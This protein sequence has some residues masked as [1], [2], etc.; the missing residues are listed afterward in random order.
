MLLGS[1]L[2]G[3]ASLPEDQPVMEQLDS[4]T[5]L[6]VARLGKPVELYLE[7]F[8]QQP[9]G[10]FAFIGPFETNS[11][12]SRALFLWVALPLDS[13]LSGDPIIEADGAP[14]ALPAPSREASSAGLRQSPYRIPTPWSAM[15]YY[16]VDE[17][18]VTKLGNASKLSVQVLEKTKDGG[19]KKSL[20]A[21]PVPDTR[22]QE[23]SAR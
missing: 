18:L 20:F 8:A 12:G 17:A 16:K 19:T 10:R 11:M 6:T 22:L 5:G 4:E 23:F 13:E 1:S 3:C 2:S 7:N 14:L 9:A 21:A 15:F